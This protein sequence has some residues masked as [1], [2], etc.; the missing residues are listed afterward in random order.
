MK[1]IVQPV[2]PALTLAILTASI[3]AFA[4]DITPP[5]GTERIAS[6]H[7]TGYQVY[8]CKAGASG[9]QWAFKAPEAELTENG[10]RVGTHYAGPTWEAADGSKVVG[11]VVSSAPS[12]G[13]IPHLL[14]QRKDGSGAGRFAK[15]AFVVR[16]DTVGGLAPS[17]PCDA[18]AVSSLAKSP[19]EATYDF[20]ANR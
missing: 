7:A 2:L 8:E 11:Q 6:L 4:A 20:Y 1:T 13:T 5:A 16:H 15:V 9:P 14:L 3:P 19:Y 17:Q 10:Q 12:A 18:A